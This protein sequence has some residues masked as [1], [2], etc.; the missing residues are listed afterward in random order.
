MSVH[1]Q[2]HWFLCQLGEGRV[3]ENGELLCSY[4]AWRFD[5]SGQCTKIPQARSSDA[6]SLQ[7]NNQLSCA[8]S[9]PTKL[10]QGLIWMWGQSCV[11]GSDTALEAALKQPE[12][13]EELYDPALSNRTV[14]T[15]WNF[16][17]L[18]YGWDMFMENVVDP[19][20]VV[21]SHHGIVGNS[22]THMK[23]SSIDACYLLRYISAISPRL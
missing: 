12:L 9:F 21:V 16:R 2:E 8:K 7:L 23:K 20:H 14:P 15:T 4:H 10:E 3:E 17:D 22:T 6:E 19:A 5:G 11:P 18:P 13:I 1:S